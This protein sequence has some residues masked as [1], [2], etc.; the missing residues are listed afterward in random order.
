MKVYAP[1]A[2]IFMMQNPITK[3]RQKSKVRERIIILTTTSMCDNEEMDISL[4]E[5]N[6]T[7]IN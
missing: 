2:L 6:K 3:A 4:L 1:I 5:F 7:N